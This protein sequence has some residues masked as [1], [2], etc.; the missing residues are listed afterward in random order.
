MRQAQRAP[1][2]P[3]ERGRA[4]RAELEAGPPLIV[5]AQ[6]AILLRGGTSRLKVEGTRAFV[7]MG[8]CVRLTVA[9]CT[10]SMD[11]TVGAGLWVNT[12]ERAS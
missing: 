10:S 3:V 7:R 2:L 5:A 11:S 1:E 12:T 4:L 8:R 9:A 6:E